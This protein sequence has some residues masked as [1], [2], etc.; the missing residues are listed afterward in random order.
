MEQ[1]T[2]AWLG[3]LGYAV[4]FGPTIAPGKL[5]AERPDDAQV[6]LEDRLRQALAVLRRLG[7]RGSSLATCRFGREL[8]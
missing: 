5:G 1:A 6:I 4:K 7:P 2:L 8:I 3:S